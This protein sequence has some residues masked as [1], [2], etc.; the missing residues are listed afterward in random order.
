MKIQLWKFAAVLCLVLTLTLAS[1]GQTSAAAAAPAPTTLSAEER[2]AAL[3][4]LQATHDAFLKSIA[5]LSE[6]QWRFKPAPDRWSVAEVAEHIAVSESTLLGLV[7]TKFM[8]S[9]ADPS[10]R[11]E[12]AGKDQI[13]MEKVPDRSRKAQAP[14]FLKPTNRW[15]TEAELTK[16]FDDSRK[17]TM[18]YIRTTND[19][20]RDHFGPH[21]LLGTLD[22]YQWIL[23]ISAHSERHTKQI[24]EVKADP[25]FPKE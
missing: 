10:K 3:T 19:D 9:P 8:M 11:A 1:V 14:E 21:P 6:K 16:A 24:E 2:A 4:S 15:A 17:A 23:L 7:Q 20:L 5:G 12:V 18:D 13:I 22:A 25:N